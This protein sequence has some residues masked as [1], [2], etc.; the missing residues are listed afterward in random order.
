MKKEKIFLL[1]QLLR[2]FILIYGKDNIVFSIFD[3][4]GNFLFFSDSCVDLEGKVVYSSSVESLY[5]F[6]RSEL[7]SEIDLALIMLLEKRILN[8]I[9]IY[10]MAE[11]LSITTTDYIKVEE[12]TRE[13]S[14]NQW[15]EV[16]NIFGIIKI[17]KK[18]FFDRYFKLIK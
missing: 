18:D 12:G 7:Y 3:L 2:K 15:K 14:Q 6:L 5:M 10:Q 8:N 16:F 1:S 9:S 11:F 13:L 17:T 4:D